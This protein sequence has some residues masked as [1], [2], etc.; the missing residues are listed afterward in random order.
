MHS[1]CPPA[2]RCGGGAGEGDLFLQ[3]CAGS[4][5]SGVP[6]TPDALSAWLTAG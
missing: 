5:A 2:H 3:T 6:P 1:F 4:R